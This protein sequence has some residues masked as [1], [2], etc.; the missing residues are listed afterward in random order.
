M[1]PL[2]LRVRGNVLETGV[3]VLP[4]PNPIE[5]IFS[6][7][8]SHSRNVKNWKSEDMVERWVVAGL[9][10][11]ERGFRRIKAFRD[12]PSFI[13]SLRGGVDQETIAA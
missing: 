3:H 9:L 1:F 12:L 10:R 5:N 2:A 13:A 11:A 6:R 4:S 7:V 8:R